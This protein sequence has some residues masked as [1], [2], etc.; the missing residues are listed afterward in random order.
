MNALAIPAP[1]VGPEPAEI[2]YQRN[3]DEAN[4]SGLKL[5][6]R[7]PA[8]FH[9]WATQPDDEKET[10]ALRFGKAFHCA[11]LEPDVFDRTY[12]VLPADAPARWD[13][14]RNAKN[15]SEGT[16]RAHAFWDQWDAENAGR[17]NLS[18]ADYERA[19]RMADSV[20][21]HPVAAG[22][23]VGGEREATFRWHDPETGLACKARA[24][25]YVP[26]EF[27][28]DLKSCMDASKE[29]FSRAV[30]RYHYDL[31]QA[32]YI[33]GIRANRDAIRWFVFC[34]VESEA[35]Y[36]CQPHVLDPRAEERGWNNRQR[37]IARQAQCVASG[38]WPGYSDELIEL[39]LPAY[40]YFNEEPN[41]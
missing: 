24:D 41:A 22:L 17:I 27:L 26:G 18:A 8:H 7:S 4:A 1:S 10:A 3:L 6:L 30:A 23:L 36:V 29:G 21:A 20:R 37:A 31:Q 25:L 28:M 15:K 33:E 38:R 5:M 13:H 39:S 14:L 32:H 16:L 35:P 12:C 9:W 34:A 19:R 40:A 2:Y 11:T